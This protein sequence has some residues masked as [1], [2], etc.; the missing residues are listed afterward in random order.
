MTT[1]EATKPPNKKRALKNTKERDP[2]TEKGRRKRRK[3]KY[4][5]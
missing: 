3:E 1:P 2:V 4:E 5:R